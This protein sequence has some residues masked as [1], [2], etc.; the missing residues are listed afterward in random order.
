MYYDF[1]LEFCTSPSRRGFSFFSTYD[2]HGKAE[3][4]YSAAAR[5]R[6]NMPA[7]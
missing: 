2:Y 3:E 1:V 5:K 7:L 4:A 6:G